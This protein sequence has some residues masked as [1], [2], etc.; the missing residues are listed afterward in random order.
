VLTLV[1]LSILILGFFAEKFAHYIPYSVE[2]SAT[3][4]FNLPFNN[5]EETQDPQSAE[6]E[7]Y[8]QSLAERIVKTQGLPD[9]M[10]IT[11]HYVNNDTVNAFATLGGHIV[12]F[13]GLLEQLTSENALAMVM[14]HEIAHVKHR[15][16]IASMGRA[17]VIGLTISVIAGSTDNNT[18]GNLLG[19]AGLLTSLTFSRGVEREA[20][21]TALQSVVS[22]YGHTAGTKTLFKILQSS[23][24]KENIRAPEFL[25]SHPVTQNR[26]ENIDKMATTLNW[27]TTGEIT[28]LPEEIKT[29]F[30]TEDT[31][32]NIKTLKNNI[33]ADE[34]S[35]TGM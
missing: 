33:D 14:S 3:S 20:D 34:C 32:K 25:S 5:N 23:E 16:P 28:A 26:I 31:G 1:F 19:D 35:D 27:K 17:V 13:L 10:K 8:L 4:N 2:V 9:E 29:Y 7:A 22:L 6:I 21:K 24:A 15:H 18:L 30:N 11:V 12:F